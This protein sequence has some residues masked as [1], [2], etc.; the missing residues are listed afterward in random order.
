[1]SILFDTITLSNH[2]ITLT[3]SP[4]NPTECIVTTLNKV[5]MRKTP[6]ARGEV[7]AAVP[8]GTALTPGKAWV[9]VNFE[10]QQGWL[11]TGFVRQAAGCK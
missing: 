2:I 1:M 9:R 8:A 11:A 7:T 6:E 10:G 3:F 4:N 5:N